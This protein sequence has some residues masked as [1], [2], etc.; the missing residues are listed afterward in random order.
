MWDPAEDYCTECGRVVL[1]E[2]E[3]CKSCAQDEAGH[4]KHD[5]HDLDTND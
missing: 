3:L 5:D 4:D 2:R 1:N